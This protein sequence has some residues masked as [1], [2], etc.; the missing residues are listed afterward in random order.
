M[1]TPS[2]P[3]TEILDVHLYCW[4]TRQIKAIEWSSPAPQETPWTTLIFHLLGPTKHENIIPKLYSQ[5]NHKELIPI[6][7]FLKHCVGCTQLSSESPFARN[8]RY[9]SIEH[10]SIL[11]IT[12]KLGLCNRRSNCTGAKANG[13]W[14]PAFR[15]RLLSKTSTKSAFDPPQQIKV[16]TPEIAL[17]N[18]DIR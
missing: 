2:L 11:P 18:R 9:C 4:C 5:G 1:Y 16:A 7:I 3:Q 8:R 15:P 13:Y 12:L 10:M 17:S 6:R 14:T